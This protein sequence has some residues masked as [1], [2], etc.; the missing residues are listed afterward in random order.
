MVWCKYRNEIIHAL[1]NKHIESLQEKLETKVQ[2]GM[3]IAR[4]ID[5]FVSKTKRRDIIRKAANLKIEK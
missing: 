3:G 4:K 2:Q 1:M 5:S